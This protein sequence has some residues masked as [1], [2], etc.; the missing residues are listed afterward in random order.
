MKATVDR[1]MFLQ[2]LRELGHEPENFMQQEIPLKVFSQIYVIT[3]EKAL[4]AIKKKQL[5]AIYRKDTFWISILEAAYFYH[6]LKEAENQNKI[7]KKILL[8]S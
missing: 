1:K 3:E 6:C 2:A 4:K 5:K 8:T 7:F